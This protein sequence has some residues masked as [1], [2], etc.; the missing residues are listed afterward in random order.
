MPGSSADAPGVAGEVGTGNDVASDIGE[1]RGGSTGT[2]VASDGGAWDP[3]PAHCQQGTVRSF[4]SGAEAVQAMAGRW[5]YCGGYGASL[6]KDEAIEFTA[7]GQWFQLEPD[8][9]GALV[10]QMSFGKAGQFSL[11]PTTT[12]PTTAFNFLM[13]YNNTGSSYGTNLALTADPRRLQ[14]GPDYLMP[15][16]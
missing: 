1:D 2:D 14:L 4:A 16:D 6:F 11:S 9:T 15:A 8:A 7:D 10:R 13:T 12:S 5:K 3:G